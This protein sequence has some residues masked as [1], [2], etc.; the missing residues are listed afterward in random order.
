[1]GSSLDYASLVGTWVAAIAA[2]IALIGIVG[3]LLVIRQTRSERYA[4]LAAV[5]DI[6]NDF[7]SRGLRLSRSIVL[8]REVRVPDISHALNVDS[9]LALTRKNPSKLST[10]ALMNFHSR[11]SPAVFFFISGWGPARD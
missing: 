9:N 4:V 6:S 11:N 3:P 2:L 10:T 5:D 7:V 1:M 8:L